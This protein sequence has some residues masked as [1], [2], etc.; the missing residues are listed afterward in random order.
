MSLL[1]GPSGCYAL[2]TCRAAL[3][4]PCGFCAG[5]LLCLGALGSPMP[6]F[7]EPLAGGTVSGGESAPAVTQLRTLQVLPELSA[8]HRRAHCPLGCISP[9]AKEVQGHATGVTTMGSCIGSGTH[10]EHLGKAPFPHIRLH[11]HA[12]PWPFAGRAWTLAL[13]FGCRHAEHPISLLQFTAAP[14]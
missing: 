13:C 7:A 9:I 3:C 5:L 4:T 8:V 11:L 12:F 14:I 1:L 6:L 10:S 2:S